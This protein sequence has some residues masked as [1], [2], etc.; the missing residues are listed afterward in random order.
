MAEGNRLQQIRDFVVQIRHTSTD[1]IVGTGFVAREGIVTCAHVVRDAGVDPWGRDGLDVGIYYPEREGRSSITKRAKVAACF[2]QHDDDVVLLHLVD[3]PSPLGP[4]L[5]AKFGSAK[6]SEDHDFRSFG[7]RRLQNYQGLPAFGKIVGHGEKPRDKRFL[8]EPLMLSSQNIDKGMSG[9]P[10]LDTFRNLIIGIIY[11][12]WDSAEGSHDRDTGLSVDARVLSLEPLCLALEENDLPRSSSPSPKIDQQKAREAVAIQQKIIWNNA[13]PSLAE[14][15]GREKLLEEIT[16]DWADVRVRITGLIGFGGEGKSSLAREWVDQLLA[17]I[18]RPQPEGTF[19]W[20]FY[21]RRNVDEFFD[22]AMNYLSGGKIDVKK[23]PSANMKAQIVTSMLGAGR[24]L[25]VLDGLEVLQY[26]DGDMYGAIR[27]PDLKA[28]LEFFASPDHESFCLISSRAP[29]MDMISFATYKHRDVNRLSPKDGR[30]L[31]QNL[32]VQGKNEELDQLVKDWDGHALTLSLLASYLKDYH[33]G[34]IAQVYNIPL[35]TADEP[36][37][38]RVRRILRRY[39]EHLEE[40]AKAFL[41]LFSAFRRPVERDAFDKIFRSKSKDKTLNA[42]ITVLDD[43]EFQSMVDKLVAYRILRYE[44]MTGQYTTHPLIR[45]HYYDLLTE[46][47][48]GL[49]EEAHQQIME[50]YL[51]EAQHMPDRPTLNDLVPL[52][53]A[54]HHACQYRNFDKAQEIC[55]VRIL[56]RDNNY[57]G[58]ILGSWET[59]LDIM[60]EFFPAGDTSR[61]PFVGAFDKGWIFNTVGLSLVNMGR[62][63]LAEKFLERGLDQALIHENW[64]NASLSY[65]NLSDSYSHRSEI[66]KDLQASAEAVKLAQRAKNTYLECFSL[67]YQ[68]WAY[69][70]H[71]DLVKAAS[72]FLKAEAKQKEKDSLKKYLYSLRGINHAEHLRRQGKTDYARRVTED[73]L[74]ICEGVSWPEDISGCHRIMG[75]LFADAGRE[76]EARRNYGQALEI[77]RS[78]SNRMVLVG[79]LLS[80]GRLYARRMRYIEAALSDLTEAL[81]YARMGGYRLHESDIR[82]GLAWAHLAAGKDDHARD[83]AGFAL[84]MSQDMGYYWGIIDAKEVLAKL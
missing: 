69:H 80:R 8:G 70:L 16:T 76:Q 27:S 37:Y 40:S 5:A 83:E 20:G 2:D 12:A 56:K 11:L 71:G 66:I 14:W 72:T 21:E 23:I 61:E 18:S 9:A 60:K 38:D 78:I 79:A 48:R 54:F 30:N 13:P 81:E 39:D 75:E 6:G 55:W 3:G 63:L 24:Y 4:E 28:F 17:D 29:L 35:P 43:S 57:I 33:E 15:T 42:P 47:D 82:I 10:V 7:Y 62:G 31:L 22:A 59:E 1:V 84:Q 58:R 34:D 77:A 65:Q 26:Q 67:A 19:W 25:F 51:A 44:S 73:N 49:A 53:E 64:A 74:K 68:A 52:I 46:D 36:R 32:G 50:Y 45:T 41:K